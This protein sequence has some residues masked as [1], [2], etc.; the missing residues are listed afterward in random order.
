M[1]TVLVSN[2]PAPYREPVYELVAQRSPNPFTVMYCQVLEPDRVLKTLGELGPQTVITNGYNP[3]HL[4]AFL[5]WARL[6]I[7]RA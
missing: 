2:I 7:I 4:L 6:L 1:K 5:W 3:T